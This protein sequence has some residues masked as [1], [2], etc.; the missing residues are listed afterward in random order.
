MITNEINSSASS[1]AV[2]SA[3]QGN[4][5]GKDD[6]LNLLITQLQNQDPLN[7]TDSTE[8][9][10]QLAQF[11]SLEQLGNVNE[12]LT[13][14]KHFQASINN[15]QAVALIGKAITA[16]GNSIQLS[17]KGPAQCDFSIDDDAAVVVATVYDSTGKYVAD[18]ESRNLSD[19]QHSLFWDGT[20]NHGNRMPEGNYTFEI[21][22]ADAKG[23]DVGSTTFF[24]GTVDRVTFENDT[25]YLISGNQKIALGN[26]IEVA[27]V[28]KAEEIV[29]PKSDS[30]DSRTQSSNPLINGGK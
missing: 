6:F 2:L 12:N 11:S 19:G 14:L 3:A 22:A 5:M 29:N 28:K 9:T 23:R 13:E 18:F 16:A 21:L 15:S 7:P 8:F 24:S 10:A 4:V 26:V 20:D 25:S 27:T 30:D 1:G 17:D